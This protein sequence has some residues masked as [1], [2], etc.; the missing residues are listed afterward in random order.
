M[1]LKA[2]RYPQ[3]TWEEIREGEELPRLSMAIT[4]KKIIM[5][6]ATTWDFFPG[7]HD[8]EYARDQNQKTIYMSTLFFQGLVDR[9][10]TDWAGPRTFITK[11]KITM[12]GSIYA[13]DDLY[14]TG[15]VARRY[16]DEQGRS[17]VDIEIDVGNQ[18][19]SKCPSSVT[20][21]LPCAEQGG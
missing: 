7:H 8:P 11:R 9:L 2:Q 1:H 3:K 19:G 20:A 13:G 6:A 12:T 5:N 18:E 15:R 14:A 21:W 17:L 10:V 4:Y 16:R